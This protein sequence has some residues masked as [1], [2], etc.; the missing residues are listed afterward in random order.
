MSDNRIIGSRLREAREDRDMTMKELG[1]AIQKSESTISR[2]ESGIS[3]IHHNTAQAL[4]RTLGINPVWLQGYPGASKYLEPTKTKSFVQVPV[5]GRIACGQPLIANEY[6]ESYEHVATDSGIDFCL[7]AQGDS[8][9]NARIFDGD[10]VYIKRQ[11]YAENGDIVAVL[12]NGEDATLKRFHKAN[13][14][15]ILRAENPQYQDLVFTSKDASNV[16]ILG[17]AVYLKTEVR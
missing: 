16:K 13:S 9:I 5:L 2:Y 3:T 17:K 8:M 11:S 14:H 15:I 7:I 4:A 10:I 12:I 6:I 1:D